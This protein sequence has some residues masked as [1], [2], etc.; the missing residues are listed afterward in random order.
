[1]ATYLEQVRAAFPDL[2][3]QGYSDEEVVIWLADKNGADRQEIG[4]F[5]G[6]YDPN[7]GDFS[8][9]VSSA[10]DATQ[11]MAYGAGALLADTVG[12]DN[13]RDKMLGGYRRN[14]SQIELRSKPTDSYEGINNFSDAAAFAKYYSGYGLAQGVQAIATGGLG[15]IVG[16]QVVKQGLKRAGKDLLEDS[17]R[18]ALEKGA[19]VGSYGGFGSQAVG[20][21]LGATYGGAVDRASETGQ[22]IDDINLAKVYGYGTA[23]GLVEGVADVATAGLARF[24]PAKN[25]LET[26]ASSRKRS[27]N[28]LTGAVKGAAIEGAT[29][30]VQTGLED[31]GAGYSAEEARFFDPTSVLAGAIGGGQLGGVGGLLRTPQQSSTDLNETVEVAKANVGEQLQLNLDD[32]STPQ[33]LEAQRAEQQNK[34]EA[35]NKLNKSRQ[36]AEND[37]FRVEAQS[38]T[39]KDFKKQLAAGLEATVDDRTSD[40]GREFLSE[41]NTPTDENPTGII[42]PDDVKAARTKFVKRKTDEQTGKLNEAYISEIQ[43]RI[44]EKAKNQDQIELDFDQKTQ[45]EKQQLELD[46][47]ALSGTKAIEQTE[48]M[49]GKDWVAS[50]NYEA[51]EAAVNAPKFNRKKYAQAL[52]EAVNSPV[53]ASTEQALEG[54]RGRVQEAIE[55]IAPA[56]ERAPQQKA[57]FETFTN[58]LFNNQ[59]D[60]YIQ[61]NIRKGKKYYALNYQELADDAG[62]T[63][64][65][66]RTTANNAMKRIMPK[67]NKALGLEENDSGGLQKLLAELAAERKLETQPQAPG[68]SETNVGDDDIRTGA[69]LDDVA[70]DKIEQTLKQMPAVG[71][72]GPATRGTVTRA[73]ADEVLDAQEN[74]DGT[75]GEQSAFDLGRSTVI[76]AGS[77]NYRGV[78]KEDKAFTRSLVSSNEEVAAVAAERNQKI[79]DE[80]ESK[81][82]LLKGVWD[83]GKAPDTMSFVDLSAADKRE[84]YFIVRQYLDDQLDQSI[85]SEAALEQVRAGI[86]KI[87]TTLPTA[88]ESGTNETTTQDA[89]PRRS[90]E[91]EEGVR[92]ERAANPTGDGPSGTGNVTQSKEAVTGEQENKTVVE[93]KPVEKAVKKPKK[94]PAKKA[95]KKPE[96]PPAKLA[97]D[98]LMPTSFVTGQAFVAD[99]YHGTTTDINEFD[100]TKLG[101]NTGAGSAQEAFFFGGKPQ[102]GNSYATS[103]SE[104]QKD[105]E[106][107]R[108]LNV[109]RKYLGQKKLN[110]S[111]QST[112]E[113]MLARAA[114][115]KDGEKLL[116]ALVKA[117]SQ[118]PK[119]GT[120]VLSMARNFSPISKP[121]VQL[122]RIRMSNPFVYDYKGAKI[123]DVTY[124]SL[125]QKAKAAGHDGVVMLNTYDR[126]GKRRAELTEEDMDNIFAVFDASDITNTFKLREDKTKFGLPVEAKEPSTRVAFEQE[127]ENLTGQKT[128]SRIHV[129]DTYKEALQAIED[130]AVPAMDIERLNKAQ[131]YGWVALDDNGDPHAHF[132]LSKVSAGREKSAFLHEMGGHVGI[133]GIIPAQDQK[134]LADQISDW[135]GQNNNTLE[136]NI[137][138]RAIARVADAR[139]KDSKGMASEG[140]ILSE[141]IAYFLE[142][143]AIAGVDPS[144]NS[145]VANFVKKL[146][147]LF[148]IAYEKLGFGEASTLTTQDIVD[149][150]YGAARLELMHGVS[151]LNTQNP[152]TTTSMQAAR[153]GVASREYVREHLGGANAVQAYDT[154]AGVAAKAA[155]SLKF[156]HNIVRDN[157][158][159][160]PA[161]GRWYDAMLKVEATRNEIKRSLNDMK[162]QAR[163]LSS[164]RRAVVNKFLGESTFDQQWG[165]DPKEYHADLFA[166]K[167]VQINT[168]KKLQFDRLSSTEKQLVADIFSHGERMR[169]RKAALAKRLGVSGKFF[170]DGSLEGPY[171]PLKRFGNYVAELKSARLVEAGRA[172]KAAGATKKQKE[173]YETLKSDRNHYIVSF[174]DTEGSANRFID[175][176]KKNYAFSSPATERSPDPNRD[177]VSDS[178]VYEKVM[179]ALSASES[180]N[181]DPN[182]KAAFRNMIRGMYFQSMDERSARTSGAKRLNRA[183]YEENMLRSFESHAD[184]EAS[185]IAQMENGTEVNTALAQA[186]NETRIDPA[187][188]ESMRDTNKKRIYNNIAKHYGNTLTRNETPVQDMVSTGNSVYM[189]LTSVGYHLTNATQPM[190]VSVPRIA[191]DFGNYGNAWSGMFRGYKYSR[192]AAK[193]GM[194]METEIDLDKV[195]Q[196]YRALLKTLQ[197]RNLLDQGMEEDGAFDRFN[198]GSEV[199]NRASDV[200][201]TITS[202]LY[203]V[204]KFVEAQNRISTAIA[205]YDA[206]RANPTKLAAMK[207][208]PEQYATAVVEDTQG[209]FSQLDAPSLIKALPK[210]VTQYRKYQLLMAWHYS[211]AFNQGF[212]GE[213]PEIRAAGKK[214]LAY[215]LGHASMGAGATGIP[216]LSLAFYVSTFLG[217]GDDEPIDMERYIKEN[218]DDGP[219]GQALSRGVFSVFGLDL[220][221]KLSQGKIF[222]PLPY[223]DF[224]VGEEGARNIIMG[225]VG[226]A[227]T[228]GVNFFRAAEYFKQGDLLKGI[229]YSMP[230]GIRSAA[231]SY[232]LATEGMTTKSG[233]VVV[234]PREIDVV[235]LLINALGLPASEINSLKWTKGQQYEIQQYFN[236]ESGK[237]RR[238]YIEATRNRDRSGQAEMRQEFR[239]LQKSKDRVRPFFNDAP[240][241]L[242]R[243]SISTLL[244]S[245]SAKAKLEKREQEKLR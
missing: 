55:A 222:H 98:R 218:I 202:K 122:R 35:I 146:R 107:N 157:R 191:G 103:K 53:N 171:A 145:T 113:D 239:D 9:G 108:V 3:K 87:E 180:S 184:A 198:T 6:V 71:A 154:A 132:V 209:N 233:T 243:Q 84:V 70:P 173:L 206:A 155:L 18:T 80:V 13:A 128:N 86:A 47:P 92:R 148:R 44:A 51:L 124:L 77:G 72:D 116:T 181:M 135:A 79:D 126:A 118:D 151:E 42:D 38:F 83:S 152:M 168:G 43:R 102:T 129:F 193:I 57:V 19:K 37:A 65:N 123:R 91:A 237:I 229:E 49:F 196:E 137:A 225:A 27:T 119:N 147:D 192:A 50:G 244:K 156:V 133:D 215:S 105:A 34:A 172:A 26:A 139:T 210:V 211:S 11:G 232:R 20:T 186:N 33:Q 226:P 23:A 195:P 56:L 140:A 111:E 166:G 217:V 141:T 165:Y 106:Y 236:K 46:K 59:M 169:Q 201:G 174:F 117:Y 66:N 149:L 190:M 39:K 177:R 130:G 144:V 5:L 62:I 10:I 58:A 96:T 76:S 204:A 112:L 216:L 8:R 162:K 185:M 242:K 69:K 231:E 4:E 178:E 82:A 68:Q 127:I 167:E 95:S 110:A 175:N 97:K 100:S 235:S 40:L 45:Q 160:M 31:L 81:S 25:L 220:S 203:N 120:P 136:S 94:P 134:D 194:D 17:S 238:K 240:G 52:N 182:A 36:E 189:L 143:A 228:T 90:N 163:A 221:T 150:A 60:K 158:A 121:Q 131:P 197:D 164:E 245:P 227:G 179:G 28:V 29:E 22:S 219:L 104:R 142:E 32:P 74:L 12:A 16:K 61:V 207:M 99:V 1:M 188:P 223:V 30:G 75:A 138:R 64:K 48:R 213:T 159:S 208:T 115:M 199:L 241:A 224:E 125:I 230:K 24:G 89:E 41:L 93:T 109:S 170:R 63:G 183:G 88:E 187:D 114:E 21:E 73:D 153:L 200:L 101:D 212:L 161:L 7:Q 67:L 2:D 214:V 14:M 54:P 205:A 15:G 78:K 234:D 85:S 176:N